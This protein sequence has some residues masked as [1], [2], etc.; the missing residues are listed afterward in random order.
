MGAGWV[1]WEAVQA[2]SP[3]IGTSPIH[4]EAERETEAAK[5]NGLD[6]ES[7]MGVDALSCDPGEGAPSLPASVSQSEKWESPSLPPPLPPRT[8]LR[9][10]GAVQVGAPQRQAHVDVQHVT[11]GTSL[12]RGLQ[13]PSADLDLD[14]VELVCAGAHGP[15]SALGAG[16]VFV[17]VMLFVLWRSPAPDSLWEAMWPCLLES[18]VAL[19]RLARR[20]WVA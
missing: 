9:A 18:T 5:G 11:L 13:S 1:P 3:G 6:L 15:P 14:L 17:L 19:G 16:L 10:P 4:W 7:A 8:A 2:S 20:G 12:S